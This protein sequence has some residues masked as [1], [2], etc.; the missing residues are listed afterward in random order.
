M[1]NHSGRFVHDQQCL[2]LVNNADRD[3]LPK[4][5]PLFHGGDL[6]GHPLT[7]LGLVARFFPPAVDQHVSQRDE[8][9]RLGSGKLSPL[10][11]KEIEADIAVRLDGKLFD[12]AQRLTLR[13]R[14]R[15]GCG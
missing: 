5:R 14:I 15:N 3:I 1:D 7:F 4:D 12:V 8:R 6:H 11:N 10:G 13:R 9:R 2:V